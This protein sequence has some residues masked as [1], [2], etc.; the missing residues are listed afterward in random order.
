MK[1]QEQLIRYRALMDSTFG[2]SAPNEMTSAQRAAWLSDQHGRTMSDKELAAITGPMAQSVLDDIK[3][4]TAAAVDMAVRAYKD[5]TGKV[6]T[7]AAHDIAERNKKML[8]EMQRDLATFFTDVFTKGIKSFGDLFTSIKD[9]FLKLVADLMAQKLVTRIAGIL[10]GL[11]GSLAPATAGAQTGTFAAQHS[12]LLANTGA[13]IGGALVGYGVGSAIGSPGLGALGGAASGAAVG[14]MMAGPV[15]AV[16]GGLAGLAGGLLGGAHAAREHAKALQEA[17]AALKV[18][19]ASLRATV[20]GDT[21]G[22]Q[23]AQNASELQNSY[24]R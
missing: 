17:Q 1:Q 20:A 2:G 23:L 3:T 9:M 12:Q 22:Q 11:M 4:T 19:F 10:T 16:V 6:L 21:L 8:N 18:S 7:G 5:G 14:F 15:G 24:S 13:G